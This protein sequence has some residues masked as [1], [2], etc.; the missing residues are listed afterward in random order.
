MFAG[1]LFIPKRPPFD[2]LSQ[3]ESSTACGC[4]CGACSSWTT[5]RSCLPRWLRFV[6]GVVDSDDLPLNVSR[7]LLQDSATV[8]TI[9]KQVI[10]RVLDLLTEIAEQRAD[11]YLDFFRKFGPVL[12][13]GLHFDPSHK[14]KLGKLL[15]YES[16]R[17]EGL[18]SLDEYV[19]ACPRGRTR[20]TTRSVR[21][22]SCSSRARTSRRSSSAATRCCS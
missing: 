21:R 18:V 1:L 4:T 7:E 8:R 14:D 11:D 22:G 15:R 3:A 2:M 13:E 20:S 17:G 19:R 12:K 6:R 16:S 9:R 10:R 5:A